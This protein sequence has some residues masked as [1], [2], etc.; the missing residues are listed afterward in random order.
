[1]TLRFHEDENVE[2]EKWADFADENAKF[3]GRWHTEAPRVK[4]QRLVSI[5]PSTLGFKAAYIPSAA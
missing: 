1:M 2:P 3:F 5:R 4:P